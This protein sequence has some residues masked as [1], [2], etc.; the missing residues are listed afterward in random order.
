MHLNNTK[1]V[2]TKVSYEYHKF[3]ANES[4]QVGSERA[5]ISSTEIDFSH[6]ET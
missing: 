3:S 2:V 6:G 4:S 1:N 5:L